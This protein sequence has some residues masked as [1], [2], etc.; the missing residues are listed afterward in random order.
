VLS[1]E[2]QEEIQGYQLNLRVI[3]VAYTLLIPLFVGVLFLMMGLGDRA[4]WS[5]VSTQLSLGVGVL[6]VFA[7]ILYQRRTVSESKLRELLAHEADIDEMSRD[8]EH[9]VVDEDRKADL[10]RLS[11]EE[12]RVVS[13]LKGLQVSF[14]LTLGIN[15]VV[16]LVGFLVAYLLGDFVLVVPFAIAAVVLNVVAGPWAYRWAKR[17]SRLADAGA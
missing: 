17:L 10:A 16:A 14:L 4:N 11:P 15:E 6:V 8:S 12:L 7:A 13:A 3:W 9:G 1:S 2:I 5:A